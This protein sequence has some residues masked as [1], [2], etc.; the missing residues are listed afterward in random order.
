M[1]ADAIKQRDVL[2][3]TVAQKHALVRWTRTQ[4]LSDIT[5]ATRVNGGYSVVAELLHDGPMADDHLYAT[6]RLDATGERSNSGARGRGRTRQSAGPDEV[7]TAP[8]QGVAT[9]F[10]CINERQSRV[11]RTP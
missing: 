8:A 9:T 4:R 5:H 2:E 1:S 11:V 3:M 6:F 10:Q 7:H